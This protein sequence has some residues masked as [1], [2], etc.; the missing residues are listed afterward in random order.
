ML[1]DSFVVW[2]VE[3]LTMDS[4]RFHLYRTDVMSSGMC[5][6]VPIEA[7]EANVLRV[8]REAQLQAV[9]L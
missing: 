3:G 2:L 9:W 7:S 1:L 5:V 4:L 8:D 6:Q